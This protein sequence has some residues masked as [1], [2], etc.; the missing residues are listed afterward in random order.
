MIRFFTL[1]LL[2]LAIS[3]L[4]AQPDKPGGAVK[5]AEVRKEIKDILAQPEYNRFADNKESFLS[6]WWKKT[7][8]KILEYIQRIF[9]LPRDEH[10]L[11]RT[12]SYTLAGTVI[13][14]LLVLLVLIVRR[15]RGLRRD[16]NSP[17]VGLDFS[18][19]GIPSPLPL[20]R[21]AAKLA[22]SGDYRGAFLAAYLASISHLDEQKVLRWERGRTNWEYLRELQRGGFEG[23]YDELRPLTFVF[24][25]KVYGREACGVEDYTCALEAYNRIALEAAA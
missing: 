23:Y 2:L 15:V 5:P 8:P 24:D 10:G 9:G 25:R 17:E 20:I 21:H 16:S 4:V 19:Y 13:L 11:G 18:T 3:P 14:V 7:G 6:R 12:L 1:L 22:E